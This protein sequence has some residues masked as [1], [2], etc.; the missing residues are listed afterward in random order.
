MPTRV[1]WN[2]YVT[3]IAPSQATVVAQGLQGPPGVPG[4]GNGGAQTGLD[5][6]KGTPS[7]DGAFYWAID[8]D[9]LYIGKD[10]VWLSVPQT[11][12]GGTY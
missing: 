6:D 3:V 9:V 8:T 5:E 2:R 1:Y 7:D 10:G 4:S 12:D 11:I